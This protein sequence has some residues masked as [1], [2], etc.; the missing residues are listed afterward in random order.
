MHEF[1]AEKTVALRFF[2][3]QALK[4]KLQVMRPIYQ[5][6]ALRVKLDRGSP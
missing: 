3:E 5:V 6:V 2:E 1:S 4:T